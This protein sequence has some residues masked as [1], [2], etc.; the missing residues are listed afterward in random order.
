MNQ[1]TS[2]NSIEQNL[3]NAIRL[4]PVR[5][6]ALYALLA[7]GNFLLYGPTPFE[8][9]GFTD[10]PIGWWAI[11]TV[12]FTIA[13]SI[14][15]IKLVRQGRF[16]D[17]NPNPQQHSRGQSTVTLVVLTILFALPNLFIAFLHLTMGIPSG[18]LYWGQ[19]RAAYEVPF[20]HLLPMLLLL[21]WWLSSLRWYT[22][23]RI[24]ALTDNQCEKQNDNATLSRSVTIGSPV[25]PIDP[26]TLGGGSIKDVAYPSPQKSGQRS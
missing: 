20:F 7:L 18:F 19:V 6:A 10:A 11:A 17:A 21:C 1:P 5:I 9:L 3:Y 23:E 8:V 15:T 22:D 26:V 13:F 12:L 16:H 24:G 4:N 25:T 2:N 14:L